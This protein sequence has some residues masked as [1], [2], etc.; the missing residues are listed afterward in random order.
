PE[1]LDEP[2]ALALMMADSLLIRRPLMQVGERREAG[3]DVARVQD[4]LGS[5]QITEEIVSTADVERCVRTHQC[6]SPQ[7]AR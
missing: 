6:P 7:A 3:F 5:P 2:A 4:W 1:V